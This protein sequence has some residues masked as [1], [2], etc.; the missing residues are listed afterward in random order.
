MIADREDLEAQRVTLEQMRYAVRSYLGDDKAAA[1][2]GAVL[3]TW[4]A[5]EMAATAIELVKT[6]WAQRLEPDVQKVDFARKIP[7][8]QSATQGFHMPATVWDH[9]KWVHRSSWWA[10]KLK[11][12]HWVR[13]WTK[14]RVWT[15]SYTVHVSENVKIERLLS[16]PAPNVHLPEKTMGAAVYIE[17]RSW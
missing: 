13:S 1:L 3:S 9:Y 8:H 4:R 16:Y 2:D 6:V 10:K 14:E 15:D 17:R 5:E 11:P 12:V 7:R